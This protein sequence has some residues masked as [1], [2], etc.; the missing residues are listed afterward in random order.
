[1]LL[2]PRHE[3]PNPKQGSKS[4]IQMFKTNSET[5]ILLNSLGIQTIRVMVMEIAILVFI[6]GTFDI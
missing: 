6:I 3:I 5:R 1:M 2:N 4:E